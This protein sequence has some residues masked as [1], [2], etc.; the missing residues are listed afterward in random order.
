MEPGTWQIFLLIFL[1]LSSAFFSSAETA[2]MSLS[3]IRIKHMVEEGVKGA[4]KVAKLIENPNRLLSSI[5]IGNNVVNIGASALATSIAMDLFGSQGVAIATGVVTILVLIFGEITPKSL[6]AQN[7]EKVSLKVAGMISVIVIV[8]RPLVTVF[9]YISAPFIKLLGG[10]TSK[11][12]PFITQEELRTMV[13]VSEEEG[14]LEEEEK[15]MIFN[16]FEFGDLQVKDVMVQRVDI[17]AIEVDS[18][19]EEVLALIKSEQ[20]SRIPVYRETIDDIVGIL[21][22]KDLLIL[23]DNK[24]F[25]VEKVMREPYYTYEFK[26]IMELFRDMQKNRAYMSVVLDEYGGTVG[27]ATMEDLVEEIVGEIE[28]EYDEEREKEIDVVKEDE[29]IVVGSARIDDLND[30]IGTSIESEEFD[31][32][33]GFIIGQLGR[34][35]E[36]QEIVE[37]QNIKFVIEDVDKN[38]VMKVRIYT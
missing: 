35:P 22:V 2:L 27:I 11:N 38:R 16:V 37:Y 3:K 33:G 4:D 28:D 17:E 6:A 15:E 9:T 29:Y 26:K 36:E 31:S 30:L 32:I 5:L 20:F 1:L 23:D 10:Q 21:N 14:V 12:Q 25:S 7:S 19:Y 8:L 24:N 34:F 18:S 13:D